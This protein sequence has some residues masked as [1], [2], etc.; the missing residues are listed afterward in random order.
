MVSNRLDGAFF[1]IEFFVSILQVSHLPGVTSL[2]AA[3]LTAVRVGKFRPNWW[4]REDWERL[5]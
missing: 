4:A 5:D 1:V 2:L 3:C